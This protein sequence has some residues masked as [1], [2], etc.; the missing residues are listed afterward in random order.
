M[1]TVPHTEAS[2]RR[3]HCATTASLAAHR[4]PLQEEADQPFTMKR[5]GILPERSIPILDAGLRTEADFTDLYEAHFAQ[6]TAQIYAYLG[7]GTEAQDLV[8]EAFLRAWQRW[9]SIGG[10]DDP[11]AWVRRVAWNLAASRHRRNSVMRRFLLKSKPPEPAPGANP[12]HVALV[13]ALGQIPP[14]QRRAIVMHYVA[15]MPIADIAV[16]TGAK[17]GTVKS[18]LHRARGELAILLSDNDP[19]DATT[20][21][22]TG[23]VGKGTVTDRAVATGRQRANTNRP[24]PS[25]EPREQARK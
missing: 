7:D 17:P 18:W 19:T 2:R 5:L 10:Y 1:T 4:T 23:D 25:N 15:D 16:A 6:L 14:K 3:Q 9:N 13:E 22:C 8:Q 20:T 21:Q 11:V 24:A 12:D